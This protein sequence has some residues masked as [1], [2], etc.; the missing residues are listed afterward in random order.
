[1][2]YFSQVMIRSRLLRENGQY[3]PKSA[4]LMRRH[5]FNHEETGYFKTQK[6]A[7]VSQNPMTDPSFMTDMLKGNVTNAVPMV[8]IGGWINWMFSGF[9]TSKSKIL[10][11]VNKQLQT[12]NF[13]LTLFCFDIC[14]YML[15]TFALFTICLYT[16]FLYI[17]F[18]YIL[19][20]YFRLFTFCIR[21]V[22]NQ[23]SIV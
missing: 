9:V 2:I 14:V 8:L 1:M 3:I 21:A 18:V 17:L 20:I 13:S 4:Y 16:Y 22:F 23:F 7:P 15:F 6:R 10:K 5:F 12:L 19:F 11:N